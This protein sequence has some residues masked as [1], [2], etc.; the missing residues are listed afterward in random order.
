MYKYMA[1]ELKDRMV[2]AERAF[3][4]GPAIPDEVAA[5]EQPLDIE[6]LVGDLTLSRL[7]QIFQNVI[8]TR[9]MRRD[10]H[11]ERYQIYGSRNHGLL[12]DIL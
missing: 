5:Y 11:H 4:R 12:Q 8:R 6:E 7:N 3:Y 9:S 10:S 1:A 2:V